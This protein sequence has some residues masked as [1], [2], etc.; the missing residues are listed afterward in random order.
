MQLL[1]RPELRADDNNHCVPL[2]AL[3]TLPSCPDSKFLVLPRLVPWDVSFLATVSEAVD[4]VSQLLNVS[5]NHA[6][7][8]RLK[9]LRDLRLCIAW[10]SRIGKW[11]T[12]WLSYI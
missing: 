2:L 11:V 10:A 12:G 3:L 7:K 5:D 9:D 4:F 8:Y 6:L 1:S